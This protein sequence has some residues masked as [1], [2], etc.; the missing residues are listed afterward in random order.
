[1]SLEEV[2][3]STCDPVT[4]LL[5]I[6]RP[7][8]HEPISRLP[9]YIR[10]TREQVFTPG[11]SNCSFESGTQLYDAVYLDS[12]CEGLWRRSLSK[13]AER[14]KFM[15]IAYPELGQVRLWG[16]ARNPAWRF[17][18][19]AYV[20][21]SD[22]VMG[23]LVSKTEWDGLLVPVGQCVNPDVVLVQP[24]QDRY[25]EI[26]RNAACIAEAL[27]TQSS[28]GFFW[29]NPELSYDFGCITQPVTSFE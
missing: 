21:V 17:F 18:T 2:I 1:M 27:A 14:G 11:I 24:I 16:F 15:G 12:R 9:G 29:F 3:P 4:A 23:G 13:T 5:D 6:T 28:V 19:G 25:V 22:T 8:D 10:E 7:Y 20:F 26:I